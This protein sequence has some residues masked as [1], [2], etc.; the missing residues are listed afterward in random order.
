MLHSYKINLIKSKLIF[1]VNTYQYEHNPNLW[2]HQKLPR[3]NLHML[4]EQCTKITQK[5]PRLNSFLLPWMNLSQQNS[6]FLLWP[7]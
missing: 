7:K 1:R 5:I 4:V 6:V 2:L 3:P